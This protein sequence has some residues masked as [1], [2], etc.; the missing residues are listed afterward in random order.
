MYSANL[1]LRFL[2]EIAALVALA[3]AGARVHVALAIALP[4]VAAALWGRFAAPNSEH[5]LA[6]PGRRVVEALVFGGAAAGLIASGR[7]ALGIAYGV[8]AAASSVLNQR[9]EARPHS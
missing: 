1:A 3:Y 6:P 9:G 2:L 4:L 7:T 8:T 5:R